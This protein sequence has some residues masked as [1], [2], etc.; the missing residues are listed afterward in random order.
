MILQDSDPIVVLEPM[1]DL[2]DGGES[3]HMEDA[4]TRLAERGTQVVVD[5]TRV[6]HL[7]ARC[8]GI[9]AQAHR[10]AARNN[11]CIVL[12]GATRVQRWLLRKTGLAEV[13]S[14]HDDVA[15]AR[16]HLATL[17]RAVA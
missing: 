13:L 4:L 9:L 7:T 3:D 17:P 1:H 14:V 15:S 5:L 10:V 2:Y 16:R 8:L 12:S 6:R 11:G